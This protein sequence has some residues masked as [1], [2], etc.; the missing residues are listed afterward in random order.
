MLKVVRAVVKG[1][2]K[3]DLQQVTDVFVPP[4]YLICMLSGKI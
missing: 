4:Q 1:V 3:S 2:R